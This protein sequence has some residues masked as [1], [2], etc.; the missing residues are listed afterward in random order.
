MPGKHGTPIPFYWC[1]V[2]KYWLGFCGYTTGRATPT[3]A[4]ATPI[5]EDDDND[6]DIGPTQAGSLGAALGAGA[7][8]G[9]EPPV[10]GG[11]GLVVGVELARLRKDFGGGKVA[12]Q[13]TSLKLYESQVRCPD[14]NAPHACRCGDKPRGAWG[15][16]ATHKWTIYSFG[17]CRNLLGW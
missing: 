16:F 4:S 8:P 12:V 15:L 17:R 7:R 13:G 2:P 14:E 10:D 5:Y 9:F 1:I 3:N 11:A 6:N